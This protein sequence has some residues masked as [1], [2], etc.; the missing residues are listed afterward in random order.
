MI[1]S[2]PARP[3]RAV[4]APR[5]RRQFGSEPDGP[6]VVLGVVFDALFFRLLARSPR[7]E[8]T[9]PTTCLSGFA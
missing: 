1:A 7:V 8:E 4:M 5:L 3:S 9:L 2:R 6:D